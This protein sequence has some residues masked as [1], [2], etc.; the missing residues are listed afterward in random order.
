M[1]AVK[2]HHNYMGVTTLPGAYY[3]LKRLE[4]NSVSHT[5]ICTFLN[6]RNKCAVTIMNY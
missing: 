2:S 5:D 4:D 3:I 1:G 6:L